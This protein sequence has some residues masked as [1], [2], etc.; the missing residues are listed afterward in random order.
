MDLKA[1]RSAKQIRTY[2]II[3]ACDR[4]ILPSD[5]IKA[6]RKI[7][8]LFEPA[9]LHHQRY[10]IDIYSK[11]ARLCIDENPLYVI[12]NFWESQLKWLAHQRR[13]CF[14]GHFDEIFIVNCNSIRSPNMM[15]S[16]C[17]NLSGEI[18]SF[19][20]T[21]INKQVLNPQKL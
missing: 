17:S 16:D 5:W 15:L 19:H 21:N 12:P 6:S 2:R 18:S 20:H 9:S 1:A 3:K 10:L 13:M 4:S 11:L 14:A 8:F 7:C